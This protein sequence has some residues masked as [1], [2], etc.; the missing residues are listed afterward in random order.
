MKLQ[1]RITGQ[2]LSVLPAV[3]HPGRYLLRQAAV[4]N[5]H[6][7]LEVGDI[8]CSDGT[9]R[10]QLGEIRLPFVPVD[11]ALAA[12]V[13]LFGD[14]ITTIA[15]LM[16]SEVDKPS[17]LLPA[18]MVNEQTQVTL[19]EQMLG[20]VLQA[21][22]LHSISKRPRIDLKYE[23]SVTEISR[24][25]RLTNGTYTHLASHSECWL[26]QTLSGVQPR[27]VLARFSEDDYSTY[28][29]RV[30][31]R[32]L[33]GLDNYLTQRFQR[34]EALRYDLEQ[35]LRFTGSKGL[36]FLLT[37]EICSLW[38][39]TYDAEQTKQ[40][41]D[42]TQHALEKI[43]SQ[44]KSIRGL[45]Q[46]GLYLLV[47]RSLRVGVSL[48]RTNILTHDQ[49]YRHLSLL[50]DELQRALQLASRPPTEILAA[51][52][53]LELNYS[54]YVGLVLRHALVRYGIE[55]NDSVLWAGHELQVLQYGLE[56]HLKV[57]GAAVLE[58]VPWACFDEL[59]DNAMQHEGHRIVCWP[60]IELGD[61]L[62]SALTGAALRLSPMD[63]YT[64]E[65]LGAVVDE[66]LSRVLLSH[67][68]KPIQPLPA[69]V[70]AETQQIKELKV[71]DNS[72]QVLGPPSAD[73]TG[74]IGALFAKHAR[75]E[76][77]QAFMERIAEAR[78][79]SL[80]PICDAP[81]ELITQMDG[82]FSSNCS[83][84]NCKRYWRKGKTGH[85]E[86]QQLLNGGNEFRITGRRSMVLSMR[87][88]A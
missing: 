10:C 15:G 3:V 19:L 77:S 14:A 72:L 9:D 48:H 67:Y 66:S 26:R 50:W 88:E 78:A 49:H 34:L 80:C 4:L 52:K 39:K 79:L 13:E 83:S 87:R 62:G 8:L 68:G 73:I 71:Q 47:P 44:L 24:A 43:S 58:L 82:G 12:K 61:A 17:P 70:A 29:N 41:L 84:C 7:S 51:N 28:E 23:E 18:A 33:D 76:L 59:P 85:W 32:L 45:K 21:G 38:G 27:K 53:E 65:R 57:D 54:T 69:V 11:S 86:Y 1:D 6:T 75:R 20:E 22:H 63:L 30:Y 74:R 42:A 37:R 5:R 16:S 55:N 81:A 40:Q 25:R 31:A 64:V 56:W 2:N 36:H 46:T 35:A 60:G